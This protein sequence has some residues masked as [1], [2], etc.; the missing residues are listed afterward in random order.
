MPPVMQGTY[1][2]LNNVLSPGNILYYNIDAM[3]MTL[4]KRYS[5]PRITTKD[6]EQHHKLRRG[7]RTIIAYN[8]NS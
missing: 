1:V 4:N 6:S 7:T 8:M 5:I 3:L 2:Y